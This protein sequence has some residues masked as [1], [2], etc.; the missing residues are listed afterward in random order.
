MCLFPCIVN[1]SFSLL[2]FI[3]GFIPGEVQPLLMFLTWCHARW[4][5]VS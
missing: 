5:Q 4:S 3:L 1:G 2:G